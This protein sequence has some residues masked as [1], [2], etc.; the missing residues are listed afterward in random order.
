M[1]KLQCTAFVFQYLPA[2][3]AACGLE[4]CCGDVLRSGDFKAASF[5]VCRSKLASAS[6]LETDHT[7]RATSLS[8]RSR[9]MKQVAAL[10]ARLCR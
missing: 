6:Q 8:E 4:R 9:V 10:A 2:T 3:L 7:A 5:A 1:I